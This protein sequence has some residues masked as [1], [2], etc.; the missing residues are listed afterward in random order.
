MI[1]WHEAGSGPPLVLLHGISSSGTSWHK[2]LNDPQLQRCCRMIAWDAPGYGMS[3]VLSHAQPSADL[4]A[5]ALAQMLDE[6]EERQVVLVGH[7]LGA[8][9]AS[10]F[11]A[12]YPQRVSRLVL[13]D[14]AQG[15]G[16]A[17]L[18]KQQQVLTQRREQLAGGLE[19]LAATRAIRLLRPEADERDI[20]TV[21]AGMRQLNPQGFL[22]AV[23]LLVHEDISRWLAKNVCP[24]EVW[25]GEYDAITPPLQASALAR[26]RGVPYLPIPAAGH[27]SY[28]DNAA[29]FNRQLRRVIAGECH[30]S[31]H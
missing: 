8:L 4:Y 30:G 1:A 22:Q 31:K 27:A 6:A 5:D 9:I 12:R 16:S 25:C 3:G 28:L 21:A 7:S 29:F 13:A 18:E 14:P 19:K 11:A 24:A 26:R 2:Q 20:A 23:S 10:A 15:Y 17:P